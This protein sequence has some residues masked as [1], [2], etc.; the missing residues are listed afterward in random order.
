MRHRRIRGTT[1]MEVIISAGIGTLVMTA[2]MSIFFFGMNSWY[3]GQGRIEAEGSANQ[4]IRAMTAEL[5]EALS[6]TIDSD[7]Q[8]VTYQLPTK[9]T[10]GSYVVPMTSDGVS[11]RIALV[12]GNVLLTV[13]TSSRT[14]VRNV[15]TTDPTSNA[16][17]TVFSTSSS[18]IVRQLNILLV[19][20]RATVKTETYTN[21]TRETIYLR[22]VPEIYQ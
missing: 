11:R 21:R 1:L 6:L 15:I 19:T 12:S 17:Y 14:M 18:V 3:R 8:G 5:R 10:D 22:N 7:G 2:S 20:R 9:N 16:A 13:G 4:A